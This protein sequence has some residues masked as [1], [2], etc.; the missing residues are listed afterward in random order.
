MLRVIMLIVSILALPETLGC[1]FIVFLFV[2]NWL[3]KQEAIAIARIIAVEMRSSGY[4]DSF[5]LRV[6]RFGAK[7]FFSMFGEFYLNQFDPDTRERKYQGDVS[8]QGVGNVYCEF[9]PC[10]RFCVNAFSQK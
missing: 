6:S 7:K 3:S 8:L 5:E 4:I 10:T 1:S 2:N 9:R